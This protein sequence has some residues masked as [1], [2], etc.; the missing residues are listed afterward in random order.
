MFEEVMS[1]VH[2]GYFQ[3]E[4]FEHYVSVRELKDDSE[5]PALVGL[6]KLNKNMYS[7][8]M[9]DDPE[10]FMLRQQMEEMQLTEKINDF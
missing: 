5:L 9:T 10:E 8:L 6:S 3:H 2:L 7:Y 1:I 4:D